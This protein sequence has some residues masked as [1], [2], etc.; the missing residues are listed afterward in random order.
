M[1]MLHSCERVM[2]LLSR[3]NFVG[4]VNTGHDGGDTQLDGFTCIKALPRPVDPASGGVAIF[5]KTA[6]ASKATVVRERASMG[7]L[8]VKFLHCT[9]VPA[10][11][12]LVHVQTRGP[13]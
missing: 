6:L 8:W 11:P 4:L 2:G 9:C 10:T 13:G 1:R 7:M 5:V 3:Y 12:G